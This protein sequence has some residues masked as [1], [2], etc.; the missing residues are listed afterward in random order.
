MLLYYPL[1]KGHSISGV[2]NV[3]KYDF[4]KKIRFN[5]LKFSSHV[6]STDQL[7]ELK[8]IGSGLC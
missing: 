4:L 3:L 6:T 8:H 2:P 7:L 1:I 5:L